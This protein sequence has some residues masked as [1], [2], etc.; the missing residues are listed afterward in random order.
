[1]LT[2]NLH[3]SSHSAQF[4]Q[5]SGNFY[6]VLDKVNV[7]FNACFCFPLKFIVRQ[8]SY[9][10]ISLTFGGLCLNFVVLD[11]DKSFFSQG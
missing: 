5:T 10:L 3:G 4:L 11:L 9:L 7:Q 6:W 2:D 8:L 1:M